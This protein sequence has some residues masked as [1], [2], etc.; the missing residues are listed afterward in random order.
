MLERFDALLLAASAEVDPMRAKLDRHLNAAL[1]AGAHR[2]NATINEEIADRLRPILKIMVKRMGR[3]SDLTFRKSDYIVSSNHEVSP[4]PAGGDADDNADNPAPTG[5]N[6][7]LPP[8]AS[9]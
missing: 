8:Q 9:W 6:A 7:D 4:M 5:A 1:A 2:I 3:I